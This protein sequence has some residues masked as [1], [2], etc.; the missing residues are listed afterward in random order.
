M[1]LLI[2]PFLL[3]GTNQTFFAGVYPTAVGFTKQFGTISKSL[4][5]LS[6][7]FTGAGGLLGGGL[8]MIFGPR[9]SS[10][11]NH[12]ILNTSIHIFF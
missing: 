7:I 12:L 9:I 4:V 3:L 2:L 1:Q 8:V 11:G 5:G 6:G 10:N